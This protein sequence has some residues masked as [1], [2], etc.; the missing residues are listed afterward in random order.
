MGLDK[1]DP[2]ISRA[3]LAAQAGVARPTVTTWEK[4][5]GDFPTP[6]RSGGAEYFHLSEV[7]DWLGARTVPRSQLRPGETVGTTYR[8]RILEQQGF[9]QVPTQIEPG[10]R[11]VEGDPVTGMVLV[12]ELMGAHADRVRGSASMLDFLSLIVSLVFLRE[13]APAAWR[14]VEDAATKGTGAEHMAGLLACIGAVADRELRRHG[15][16]PG[17]RES[18]MRLEPRSYRDLVGVVRLTVKLPRGAFRLILDQYEDRAGLRSEEF[19]TPRGVVRLAVELA[20]G[21]GQKNASVYDPYVRGGEMLAAVAVRRGTV[22]PG[23]TLHG[24]SPRRDTLRFAG[25]NI[26]LHGAPAVLRSSRAMPWASEGARSGF[27]DVVL[28]NPPFNM[29][30]T[31]GAERA[32][33][34]WE[35]GAPP[36]GN[37]NLAWVQHVLNALKPGGRAIMVMPVKAGNSVNTAEREIRRN[38]IER[39]AVECVVA[40]PP[41]LF[42]ATPVPVALWCLRRNK[43]PRPEVLLVDARH[44][45]T[46]TG[47]RN[48]VGDDGLGAILEVVRPW[49]F[50]PA[51]GSV[52]HSES[53]PHT[54]LVSRGAFVESGYSLSP[55]DH[56]PESLSAAQPAREELIRTHGEA[57]R[58]GRLVQEADADAAGLAWSSLMGVRGAPGPLPPGWTEVRLAE[59]CEIQPGPSYTR[60]GRADRS[61]GGE[62]PVIFPR[63]L[64]GGRILF[65]EQEQA[66]REKAQELANFR[67]TAGDVVCVRTGELRPPALVEPEQEGWLFSTNLVRL[68][69]REG[70]GV[71]PGFLV[72]HLSLPHSMQWMRNR[73]EATAAPSLSRDA[74]G[75][76]PVRF[77]SMSEQ[78]EIVRVSALLRRQAVLHREY[79]DAVVRSREELLKHLMLGPSADEPLAPSAQPL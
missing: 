70:V 37:D 41:R 73:A 48:V 3:E 43:T 67:L 61:P 72:D 40:L 15:V 68:R 28:T 19:F 30:D 16:P 34:V 77:P 33:G 27:A 23:T 35:F 8:V 5:H 44:L 62:V 60:L 78:Q 51:L 50:G 31:A 10:V 9:V 36:Q 59:L 12:N 29:S 26:A 49:L 47:R 42:S 46:G 4:R 55:M 7:L 79:A 52:A 76:L 54:T 38:L 64:E 24:E 2:L 1:R 66:F 63:Q 75:H 18:L 39:G 14:D 11:G 32:H 25:M 45:G 21:A 6:V 13:T 20:L 17:M 65:L 57:V 74:L 58:L 22:G 69:V 56:I 53:C 71:D